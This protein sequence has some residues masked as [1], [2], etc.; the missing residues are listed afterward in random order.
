VAAKSA[1]GSKAIPLYPVF[2]SEEKAEE[3]VKVAYAGVRTI[4]ISEAVR[5]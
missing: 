5:S 3:F 1:R 2:S 4:T